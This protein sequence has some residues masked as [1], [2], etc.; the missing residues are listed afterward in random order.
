[1]ITQFTV[2]GFKL[3]RTKPVP[4]SRVTTIVGPNNGGKTSLLQALMAWQLALH[5]WVKRRKYDPAS[6]Q[7]LT[8][9]KRPGVRLN[10]EELTFVEVGIS[11]ELWPDLVVFEGANKPALIKILV[12][13]V[14]NST[15]WKCGMEF[16]FSDEKSVNVRPSATK[17][18]GDIV[19]PKAALEEVIVLN[20]AIHATLP[21][22]ELLLQRD[23][24]D[25]MVQTGQV[26][27]ALRSMLYY[28]DCGPQ[29]EAPADGPSDGWKALTSDIRTMFRVDIE[30]PKRL[31]NSQIEVAYR[32]HPKKASDK[33]RPPMNLNTAGSGFLQML[34]LLTLFYSRRGRATLFLLDEPEAHLESIRQQDLYRLLTQRAEALDIQ[35]VMAS[36]S[37]QFMEEAVQFDRPPERPQQL[38]AAIAGE[39]RPLGSQQE[40]KLAKQAICDIPIV[41]YYDTQRRNLWLYVE[42]KSDVDMLRAW[43]KVLNHTAATELF[44]TVNPTANHH[45]LKSNHPKDAFRHFQ[46]LRFLFPAVRGVVLTDRGERTPDPTDPIPHL[47]WNRREIENY[48]LVWS[49]IERAFINEATRNGGWQQDNPGELFTRTRA[50]ELRELMTSEF[51]VSAALLDG[52]HPDLTNKKASD[53]VL[54]PFYRKAFARYGIYNTLPKNEFHRIAEQMRPEEVHADV[55][56][57]LNKIV[58]A[59][60]DVSSSASG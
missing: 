59:L 60:G 25:F 56:E 1:M 27:R 34:Q 3:L 13:G 53:E 16:Q 35:I 45:Y 20:S 42:D 11:H 24:V 36:H 44:D 40:Q 26:N 33:A 4:L 32:N 7:K 38:L 6:P 15:V 58:A 54:V 31:P 46:G 37:E 30:R 21:L 19:I 48:L 49:V 22:S 9:K 2:E 18:I 23:G 29:N 12:E 51:L 28:L 10:L 17:E 52:N 57:M 47:M 14:S 39:V 41:D 5:T 8:A 43:A 55:R 50:K